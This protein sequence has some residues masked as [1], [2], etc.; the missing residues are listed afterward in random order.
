MSRNS[1]SSS[2][3]VIWSLTL[4]DVLLVAIVADLVVLAKGI[5]RLPLH[6]PGHSGVVIVALFIVG[7]G[8]ID[9]RGAGTLIGLLAGVLAVLFGLGQVALVTW[10]KYLGMGATV[11]VALLVMPGLTGSRAALVVAGAFA[12]VAKLT[13]AVVI[14]LLLELPLGFLVWGLGYTATTHAVFGAVGGLLGYYLV[15]EL[16]KVPFFA[17]RRPAERNE[18]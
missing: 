14:G 16:R 4:R 12:N 18:R 8:L 5:M 9:R 13:A 10:V 6:V 7:A 11:D 17:A 2:D 15:R 1:V 3:R